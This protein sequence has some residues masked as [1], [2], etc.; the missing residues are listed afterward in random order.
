MGGDMKMRTLNTLA[1]YI[2]FVLATLVISHSQVN[3]TSIPIYLDTFIAY[4]ETAVSVASDGST[5]TLTEDPDYWVS[6][7]NDPYWGGSG[8]QV[9]GSGSLEIF[10]DYFFA[11]QSGND[12]WFYAM[13]FF[14]D[15]TA[16][17][18]D[19]NCDASSSGTAHW[20]LQ[21]IYSGDTGL[22][23]E[24]QLNSNPVT[25]TLLSSKVIISNVH[26]EFTEGSPVPEPSTMI[27][28]GAALAGG[29]CIRTGR[30]L[31]R[32]S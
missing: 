19:L 16:P 20:K 14:D 26:L 22:V 11:E 17:L 32:L 5:A 2:A 6:L 27:L 7:S 31:K 10:F 18:F 28:L 9:S 12:D 24:F 4:P 3:A 29:L 30:S 15:P 25:D 1:G 8:I 21:G 13:V 23:L